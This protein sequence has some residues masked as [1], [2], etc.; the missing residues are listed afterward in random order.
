MQ[1]NGEDPL[2]GAREFAPNYASMIGLSEMVGTLHA[3][4]LCAVLPG[5]LQAALSDP[6]DPNWVLAW[7]LFFAVFATGLASTI[8]G[9]CIFGLAL[10]YLLCWFPLLQTFNKH[11]SKIAGDGLTVLKRWALLAVGRAHH[12]LHSDELAPQLDRQHSRSIVVGFSVLAVLLVS[13]AV[14]VLVRMR[15]QQLRGLGECGMEH[16]NTYMLAGG[17]TEHA[18]DIY[19]ESA[20]AS[21]DGQHEQ[22]VSL[23]QPLLAASEEVILGS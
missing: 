22:N 4:L 8:H 19:Q 14:A 15:S 21:T 1:A 12:T 7:V 5:T 13:V 23:T 20:V 3:A 11:H 18:V 2:F 16:T 9:N 6:E 17:N 10:F